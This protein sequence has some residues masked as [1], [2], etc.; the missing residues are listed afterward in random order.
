[1]EKPATKNPKQ[2]L[3]PIAHLVLFGAGLGLGYAAVSRA[4]DTGSLLEYTAGLILFGLA[5]K[6]LVQ[7]YNLR[8]AKK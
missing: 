6:N 2:P 5:I 3:P 8:K 4:I 1:M 7:F